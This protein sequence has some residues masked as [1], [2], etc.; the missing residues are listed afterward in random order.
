MIPKPLKYGVSSCKVRREN[1]LGEECN[2]VRTC[3]PNTLSCGSRYSKIAHF[4]KNLDKNWIFIRRMAIFQYFCQFLPDRIRFYPE[5][6]YPATIR[7]RALAIT[8][9]F[10]RNRIYINEKLLGQYNL[11]CKIFLYFTIIVQYFD[12]ISICF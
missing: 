9:L 5:N 12:I 2:F 7:Q 10:L 4:W 3:C 6:P 11:F 8:N 1:I